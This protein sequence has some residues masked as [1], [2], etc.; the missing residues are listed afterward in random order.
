MVSVHLANA[1]GGEVFMGVI[2]AVAFVTI[3]AVVAGLMLA[4]VTALTHDLYSS[5]ILNGEGDQSTQVRDSKRVAIGLGIIVTILSIAFERQNIA[6]LVSLTLAIA[7]STNFPLLILSM[8]WQGLTTR[9]AI[10]GGIFGLLSAVALVILGPSVWVDI[11]GNDRPIFPEAYPA[12]YSVTLAFLSMW[13]FSKTDK[14][15]QAT[16]D[17]KNFSVMKET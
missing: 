13:F 17:R 16:I 8:Y 3:L 14:S 4:S 5:A 6:Y 10:F 9:G 1:V 2:A 15:E 7:A 11:F 12:L